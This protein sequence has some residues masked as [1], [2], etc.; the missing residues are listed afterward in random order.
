MIPKTIM[1]CCALTAVSALAGSVTDKGDY[2]LADGTAESPAE[3]SANTTYAKPLYVGRDGE[4]G[5]LKVTGATLTMKDFS[6]YLSSSASPESRFVTESSLVLDNA[7]LNAPM[8]FFGQNSVTDTQQFGKIVATVKLIGKSYLWANI[9]AYDNFAGTIDFDGGALRCASTARPLCSMYQDSRLT[10]RAAAEKEIRIDTPAD[11]P[12]ALYT[13]HVTLEGEGGFRKTGVNALILPEERLLNYHGDTVVDE[14]TLKL[15]ISQQLPFGAGRGD[16]VLGGVATLDL[17]GRS[18]SVNAIR[19]AG[20]IV[21]SAEGTEAVLTV[22]EDGSS[23]SF[24][25]LAFGEGVALDNVGAGTL[26]AS[27]ALPKAVTV[28]G[29][30]LKLAERQRFSKYRF[31]VDKM[32]GSAA[33]VMQISEFQLLNGETDV[34]T[35]DAFVS[36]ARSALGKDPGTTE[37]VAKAVDGSVDTKWVEW[38]GAYNSA[39]P[40]ECYLV[41][42]YSEPIEVSAYRWATANDCY[43]TAQNTCRSPKDFRLQGSNDGGATWVDLDVRRG[44]E[45]V[46]EMKKWVPEN[47]A[48]AALD[49]TETK[50]T[51]LPGATLEIPFG[52][53]VAGLENLG[54][55]VLYG[56]DY[57]KESDGVETLDAKTS[58]T[59]DTIIRAGT[60]KLAEKVVATREVSDKYWRIAFKENCGKGNAGATV[61]QLSEL[62]LYDAE[63]VRLT[64]TMTDAGADK[65]VLSLAAGEVTYVKPSGARWTSGQGPASLLDGNQETKFCLQDFAGDATEPASWMTVVWRLPADAPAVAGYLFETANDTANKTF[66]GAWRNPKNWCL[67]SSADGVHWTTVDAKRDV[68]S[69]VANYTWYNGGNPWGFT[70]LDGAFSLGQTPGAKFFRF[71]VRKLVGA[72]TYKAFQ[73]SELGLFAAD[74]SRVNEGLGFTTFGYDATLVTGTAVSLAPGRICVESKGNGTLTSGVANLVDGSLDTK[75]C[76]TA[77]TPSPDAPDSQLVIAM[78]LADDKP[79]AVSYNMATGGDTASYPQR[80]PIS[81][82][83]ESS[84]DGLHWTTVAD[85]TDGSDVLTR[86]N[87]AWFNGGAAMACTPDAAPVLSD[88]TTVEVAAGAVLD[89]SELSAKISGLRISMRDGAGTVSNFDPQANGTLDL[90]DVTDELFDCDLPISL[91]SVAGAAEAVKGWSVTVNGVPATNLKLRLS[92]AGKLRLHRTDLGLMLIFK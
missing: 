56:G 1:T 23:W 27:C 64:A 61:M 79:T 90:V 15:G 22:G 32:Y 67:Q 87:K 71:T 4:E 70:T 28:S 19:G 48:C 14:G 41:L 13:G 60:L 49:A 5:A 78:R 26:V 83:L 10:L 12:F 59:G 73:L 52:T 45:G 35:C 72:D 36:V 82:K 57:V 68:S 53:P 47:F 3:I 16:L 37:G 21:N 6:V 74:G 76:P 11:V 81:W 29:G 77:F 89:G 69:L 91:T 80:N 7:V 46:C 43:D 2:L 50:F 85:V 20:S 8:T 44:Y 9:L 88:G 62:S 30:T 25:K 38:N 86:E 51:V 39:Y 63:G 84:Y 18:T 33:V 92:S 75:L 17:S 24:G 31:K 55:T 40:D 54:G 42:A 58:W 34:T 65:D 66:N